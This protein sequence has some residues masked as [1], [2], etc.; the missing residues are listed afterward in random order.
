[1]STTPYLNSPA[2]NKDL[3]MV[4]KL[5]AGKGIGAYIDEYNG[6]HETEFLLAR[7]SKFIITKVE[8]E[9]GHYT[10]EMEL[11]KNDR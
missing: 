1:M 9:K 7:D 4:I 6:L 11:I 3:T 2:L 10:V 5:P 8:K